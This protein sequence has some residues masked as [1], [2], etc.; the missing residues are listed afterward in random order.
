[1][2]PTAPQNFAQAEPYLW[3]T[4]PRKVPKPASEI[5]VSFTDDIR[6]HPWGYVLLALATVSAGVLWFGANYVKS[7]IVWGI[8]FFGTAILA[9]IEAKQL[10]MPGRDEN[11]KRK[12]TGPF[13]WFG[14]FLMLWI[15]AFPLYLYQR[16]RYGAKSLL[17]PGLLVTLPYAVLAYFSFLRVEVPSVDS[18]EVVHMIQSMVDL[19]AKEQSL[20][21]VT[22]RT[23][24]EVS[25]DR[26]KDERV[27][28][29]IVE[30]NAGKE[31][32][33]VTVSWQDR[34]NGIYGIRLT[35][36]P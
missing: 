30:S 34:E 18:R 15:F 3:N 19:E 32:L 25:Y 33:Y 9:A 27:G 35:A 2:P 28:R 22:V 12:G 13:A 26:W 5:P 20:G 14:G 7:G 10:G 23:P 31:T 8:T 17:A 29:V 21:Q 1:M 4:L 36:R 16:G 6:M 11:G 24:M